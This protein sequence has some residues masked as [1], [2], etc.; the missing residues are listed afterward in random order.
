MTYIR[1][2]NQIN[3]PEKNRKNLRFGTLVTLF[4]KIV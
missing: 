1:F 4:E 2:I 3:L